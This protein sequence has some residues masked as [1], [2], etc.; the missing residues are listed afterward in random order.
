[1]IV[2]PVL[3]RKPMSSESAGYGK[4]TV[5]LSTYN[6]SKFLHEQL[7]SLYQ[8]TYPNVR[9]LVRDDGS[10]DAT[11]DLLEEA[12]VE[13]RITLLQGHNNLGVAPSFFELLKNAIIGIVRRMKNE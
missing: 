12:H 11:R 2:L 9:I 5:L 8:Q 4:V 3:V 7:D 1:M 10:V 6:G 13:G